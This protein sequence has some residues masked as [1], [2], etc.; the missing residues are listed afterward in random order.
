MKERNIDPYKNED[1]VC[2]GWPSTFRTVKNDLESVYQYTT[3]GYKKLEDLGYL[4]LRYPLENHLGV[5]YEPWHIK[6][7]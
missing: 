2:I 6:V 3:E 4:K 5:R 1:Y 7:T